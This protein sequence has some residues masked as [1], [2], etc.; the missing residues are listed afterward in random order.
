M[1]FFL[2]CKELERLIGEKQKVQPHFGPFYKKI[3]QNSA[4]ALFGRS[5]FYMALFEL[6]GRTI[7]QL[8]TLS[9]QDNVDGCA[10]T[11]D[12]LHLQDR[13][14]QL[15]GVGQPEQHQGHFIIYL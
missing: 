2:I 9:Y 4:A 11:A 5:T 14:L 3:G 10:K 12:C 7:G 13:G 8:A 1:I 15:L 6:C